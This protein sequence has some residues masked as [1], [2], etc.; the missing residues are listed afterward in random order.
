MRDHIN[1]RYTFLIPLF[2][3]YDDMFRHSQRL[4]NVWTSKLREKA[5]SNSKGTLN[6]LNMAVKD[7]FWTKELPTTAAS[8]MLR[9]FHPEE[10]AECVQLARAAGASFI[11]KTNCDEFGMGS[12]NRYSDFGPVLH[13]FSPERLAGG[14]SGGSAAAVALQECDFALSTDTGGSTRL[15]AS[16]CGVVGLK[17]S[18]GM[19]SRY[20][21]IPYA[22]SLD[23]VGI[24]ARKV[25]IVKRVFEVLS[26]YDE[27][28]PSS[29]SSE[30]RKR[31]ID[32]MISTK[33]SSDTWKIGLPEELFNR[34]PSEA[35][36]NVIDTLLKN[37]TSDGKRVELYQVSLPSASLALNAYY[38]LASAE[39]S[40][41]LARYDGMQYGYRS[42]T[43]S[44]EETRAE[45]F[46]EEVKRRIELG[47][48]VLS[49]DAF[50]NYYLNAQ[51]ARTAIVED[52]DRLFRLPNV[53][54]KN[55]NYDLGV[56]VLIHPT[57]VSGPP[58]VNSSDTTDYSQD[59]LTTPVSL[60][61]LPA[62]SIPI[63]KDSDG[64][65]QGV[66]IVSQWGCEQTVFNMAHELE[67]VNKKMH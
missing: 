41:S 6:D 59:V 17:P 63:G 29:E 16:Y 24:M 45:G 30:V 7:V 13:P 57:A 20:G 11:G 1:E 50:D 22:E 25:G 19:I 31:A 65:P 51:R 8:K 58:K 23:C 43:G 34:E 64:F 55:D 38:I 5:Q 21:M 27:K 62:M 47:N 39:A 35:L 26:Q 60:A 46:G 36:S 66:S 14:S 32:G 61:G 37:G 53:R 33:E 2:F 4:L 52:F 67:N 9:N 3:L 54:S 12:S 56:D 49:A 15:P 28:D 40:S 10:D 18:Y 44:V 42:K 48:F